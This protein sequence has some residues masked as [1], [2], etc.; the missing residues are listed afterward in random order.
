MYNNNGNTECD[1]KHESTWVGLF[2]TGYYSCM[3]VCMMISRHRPI[4]SSRDSP[5]SEVCM[6]VCMGYTKG[7]SDMDIHHTHTQSRLDPQSDRS[8][9]RQTD[10]PMRYDSSRSHHSA[11]H[12][13]WH[14]C[15]TRHVHTR[16]REGWCWFELT[17][18]SDLI[19]VCSTLF[20]LFTLF[21]LFCLSVWLTVTCYISYYIYI[22][23]YTPSL[24]HL[25]YY[26]LITHSH[27]LT[28]TLY[29]HYTHTILTLHSH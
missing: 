17:R 1:F 23:I 25:R 19:R 5:P 14:E 4:W 22:Y 27:S 24:S 20:S 18:H 8:H 15:D 2:V 7:T 26:T 9:R 16:I 29:S 21:C 10:C 13:V 6:H 12:T 11:T 28:L 3:S